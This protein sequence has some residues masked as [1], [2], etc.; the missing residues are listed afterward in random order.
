MNSNIAATGNE[1]QS[2]TNELAIFITFMRTTKF[3]YQTF[4][5][6]C[7]KS[8]KGMFENLGHS[9]FLLQCD[10]SGYSRSSHWMNMKP[11]LFKLKTCDTHY[12]NTSR[13]I[14][15]FFFLIYKVSMITKINL[16]SKRHKRRVWNTTDLSG[17][18][19]W[20]RHRSGL[21]KATESR[22]PVTGH[23]EQQIGRTQQAVIENTGYELKT[24]KNLL[25]VM[26]GFG[27]FQR[28]V[29]R[30]VVSGSMKSHNQSK[31]V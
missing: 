22:W 20:P 1:M 12:K 9:H 19:L 29:G 18:H 5:N 23:M 24:G 7:C 17:N 28:K 10:V 13:I 27:T 25:K 2:P 4:L 8:V 21:I 31:M 30:F 26:F 3:I 14:S 6:S 16:F 15:R 11:F